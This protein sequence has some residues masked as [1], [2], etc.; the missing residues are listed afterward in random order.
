MSLHDILSTV[1]GILSTL[2][3]LAERI[4]SFLWKEG[5]KDSEQQELDLQ[6]VGRNDQPQ[7][8]DHEKSDVAPP[9]DAD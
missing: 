8:G 3:V 7:G 1:R 2:E 4:D 5:S 6:N 9:K